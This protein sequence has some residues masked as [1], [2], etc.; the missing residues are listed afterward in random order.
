ML[1]HHWLWGSLKTPS[2]PTLPD[3]LSCCSEGGGIWSVAI[4][5]SNVQLLQSPAHFLLFQALLW[6]I[7]FTRTRLS[8][9]LHKTSY[10]PSCNKQI[11]DTISFLTSA[12]ISWRQWLYLFRSFL[13]RMTV[14]RSEVQHQLLPQRNRY[15][16]QMFLEAVSHIQNDCATVRGLFSVWNRR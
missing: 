1:S 8:R 7:Q 2:N 10:A 5:K 3:V 16:L 14:S 11:D 15:L 13:N 9:P 6:V 4:I 12:K